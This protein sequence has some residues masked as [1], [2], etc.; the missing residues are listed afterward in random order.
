[1]LLTQS[2]AN[3]CH[4]CKNILAGLEASLGCLIISL[5]RSIDFC[6]AKENAGEPLK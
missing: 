6:T 3:D 4:F 5:A 2:I 1:M